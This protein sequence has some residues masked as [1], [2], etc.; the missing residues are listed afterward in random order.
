MFGRRGTPQRG[1]PT[2]PAEPCMRVSPHTALHSSQLP[3]AVVQRMEPLT[4]DQGLATPSRQWSKAREFGRHLCQGPGLVHLKC[5]AHQIG[6]PLLFAPM[7]LRS[8][9]IDREQGQIASKRTIDKRVSV[10]GQAR[11]LAY[12]DRNTFHRFE[13]CMEVVVG[14]MFSATEVQNVEMHTAACKSHAEFI[15]A[16]LRLTD[17]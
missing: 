16:P 15:R 7:A 11:S 2:P 12:L 6:K 10:F 3:A 17:R 14:H 4:Q 1:L 5:A 8:E 13:D 9:R